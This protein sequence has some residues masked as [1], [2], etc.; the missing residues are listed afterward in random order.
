MYDPCIGSCV[1]EQEQASIMPFV[2]KNNNML[3]LNA[4]FLS[5]LETLDKSCGYADFRKKYP[6]FPA[7]GKQPPKYF[8]YPF[9]R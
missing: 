5:Q 8:N 9:D 6:T 7:A 2:V 3:G 4:S 1:W